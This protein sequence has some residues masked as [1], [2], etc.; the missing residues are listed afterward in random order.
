MAIYHFKVDVL[1]RSKGR[2]PLR[3]A[4]YY[5]G[6][7]I[8]N[9]DTGEVYDYQQ[10]QQAIYSNILAP[11][12]A[13][14][15]VF[16]RVQ[17]WHEA[18]KVEKRQDSQLARTVR[19]CVPAELTSDQQIRLVKRFVDEQFVAFGMV[20]D[21]SL[22]KPNK[23]Q[24]AR[25]FYAHVILTTRHLRTDGFCHKNRDWNSRKQLQE[26]RCQWAIYANRALEQAGC[27]ERIDHRTLAEQKR[28]PENAPFTGKRKRLRFDPA[29]QE[30]PNNHEVSKAVLEQIED[31]KKQIEEI[32][33]FLG[34]QK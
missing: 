1:T 13:P 7:K 26:W 4:A 16:D 23:K 9:P 28:A 8:T 21:V 22:R 3:A 25:N 19:F 32:K 31:V 12:G 10:H 20:A 6:I 17:L 15:W 2:T 27:V 14:E 30:Y 33:V 18:E 29:Q 5:A 11:P 34:V 24:D